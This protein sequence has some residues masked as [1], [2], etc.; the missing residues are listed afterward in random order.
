MSD[1][2]SENVSY[3]KQMGKDGSYQRKASAFRN[4]V[5]AD[6]SSGFKAEAGRYHLYVQYACPWASRVLFVRQQKGLTGALGVTVLDWKLVKETGW[7]FRATDQD[8]HHDPP[9]E[10]L[11]QLYK[12]ADPKYDGTWTVPVLWD[13][14]TNKIVNNESSEIIRMLN[15]EF[16]EFCDDDALRA[17]D[18]YPES[19]R[20]EIDAV[21]EWV[22]PQINNGVYRAG[23]A[24][25]QGA[26]DK[27]IADV[28]EGLDRVESVLSRQRY[29]CG[30][31]F[32]EAD[33]R[34]FVTLVRF[35]AVYTIHFKCVRR[36]VDMPNTYAYVREIYQMPGV[37]DT[38]NFEHIRHHYFESH[39]HINPHGI[40]PR[41]TV[42]DFAAPHDRA[43]KFPVAA[44]GAGAGKAAS[45]TSPAGAADAPPAKR[46]RQ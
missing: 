24:T 35:D 32:T 23:F 28:F 3:R 17:V 42:P 40:V 34:L 14:K 6:G 30:D 4:Q 2:A 12:E 27:A 20:G 36:V 21:N 5:T 7:R 15:S 38:V 26:Y 39:G 29:L 9:L 16:N 31:R 44:D 37:A 8:P 25:T 46:P 43:E 45:S 33:I 13:T 11:S 18:N 19:M 41:D 1:T 10:F 22:Y